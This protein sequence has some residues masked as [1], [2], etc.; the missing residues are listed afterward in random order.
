M[1]TTVFPP[2][3]PLLAQY[4]MAFLKGLAGPGVLLFSLATHVPSDPPISSTTPKTSGN[5]GI[6]SLF[7]PL[8][9]SI[10]TGNE[11]NM[12]IMYMKFMS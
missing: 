5:M 11:H 8:L 1:H 4:I 7:H 10:M 12:L 2:V 9:G 6:D 3:D